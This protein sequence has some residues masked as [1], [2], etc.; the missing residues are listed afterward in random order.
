[1]FCIMF[2]WSVSRG[3]V[4]SEENDEYDFVGQSTG[5]IL[6]GFSMIYGEFSNLKF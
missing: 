4:K 2:D 3:G 5:V 6:R 1:M